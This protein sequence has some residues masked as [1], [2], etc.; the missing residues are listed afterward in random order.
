MVSAPVREKI[1]PKTK[2]KK[3]LIIETTGSAI[4]FEVVRLISAQRGSAPSVSERK[5]ERLPR[6]LNH[7][8]VFTR[9]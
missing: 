4:C 2:Q 9:L 3:F 7:D 8:E 6:G 1:K 5:G